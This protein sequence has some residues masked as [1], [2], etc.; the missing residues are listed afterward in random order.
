MNR[1]LPVG[2]ALGLS[3]CA[4]TQAP[5]PVSSAPAHCPGPVTVPGNVVV[6]L[7][8]G[9]LTLPAGYVFD[10]NALGKKTLFQGESGALRLGPRTEL[11]TGYL[12]YARATL[13]A[14]ELRCGL[15]ILRHGSDDPTLWLL[16]GKTHYALI[17]D[18]DPARVPAI[19]DGYCASLGPTAPR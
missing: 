10:G 16:L 12:D 11:K 14:R 5:V 3:A 15:E 4:T 18:Q 8:D 9:V 7:F 6:R 13:K 17:Y 2:M 1:L 19:I